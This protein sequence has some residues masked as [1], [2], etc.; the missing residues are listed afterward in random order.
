MSAQRLTISAIVPL[1]NGAEFIEES[2]GSVLAQ[3]LPPDEIIVIDDG[4]T[5]NGTAIVERFAVGRPTMLI[6]KENGGQSSARNLGIAHATG[7]LIALLDQDDV[8]YPH[9]LEELVKPFYGKRF[10]PLG[11]T[12]SNL[13]EV[14]RQ[15]RMMARSTLRMAHWIQ[16]PKR[17]LIGCLRSDMFILPSASLM[18]REA[19]H[20]VG[21]FDERLSGFEDDDLF[22]RM[23]RA[24]YDN[25]Y[26]DSALSKWRIFRGSSSFSPRMAKS[27]MIYLRKLL[28]EYPD[29]PESARFY[30]R[31]ILAPRFFPWLVRELA[32]ALRI[33]NRV[34]I[35]NALTD[36][37][38]LARFHKI[39]ARC[40]VA[41][42]R[43]LTMLAIL[44]NQAPLLFR[45]MGMFR[46]VVRRMLR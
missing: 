20:T 25:D 17:D 10:P 19:F 35:E 28:A 15:G 40:L 3:T 24:G 31:D 5:D 33:G 38:F 12:Y 45:M 26:I 13:D 1:F 43:P 44:A 30:T 23:F 18:S 46:P 11:W 37:V 42:V 22:L 2:L 7:D 34:S 8:W 36:L 4:S 21:G 6:R 14:D 29:D 39:R 32:E 27:R 41:M 9:H 16:H